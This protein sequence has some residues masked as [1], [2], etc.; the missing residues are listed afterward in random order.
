MA[1]TKPGLDTIFCAAI[2]IASEE[3]RAAYLARA[4]GDD[5]ELQARLEKLLDA[6]VRADSFLEATA[7]SPVATAGSRLRT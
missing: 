4:C 6:H 5:H 3:E 7:C 2:E 1:A